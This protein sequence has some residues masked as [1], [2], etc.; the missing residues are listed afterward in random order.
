VTDES[1]LQVTTTD[2]ESSLILS[3]ARSGL[4]AR[5][6]RDAEAIVQRAAWDPL[7]DLRRRAEEGDADAQ[8]DLAEAH[9]Y[10]HGVPEDY[11]EE[12][13]WCRRAADQGHARAQSNLGSIY[14]NGRGVTQDSTEAAKWY[15]KAAEQGHAQAQCNL[16][17]SYYAREEYAQATLWYRKAAEQGHVQG[18]YSLGAAYCLGD[19]VLRDDEEATKWFRKAAEQWNTGAQQNTGAQYELGK[20]YRLGRG[21]Q[22]DYVQAHMWLSLA[23]AKEPRYASA[24]DEVAAEMNPAQIAEAQRLAALFEEERESRKYT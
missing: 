20:M 15:R 16:G 1:K 14:E 4:I 18:E 5:G 13:R 17:D 2:Q 21:L 10:G 23:A 8:C 9:Y 7:T 22:Q 19:G 24:R 6:R 11:A 3:K 12:F